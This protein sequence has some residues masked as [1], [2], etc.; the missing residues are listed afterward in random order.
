MQSYGSSLGYSDII[1]LNG[2]TFL[3]AFLLYDD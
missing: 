2:C 1:A 3:N